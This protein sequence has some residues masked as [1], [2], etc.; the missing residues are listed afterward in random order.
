MPR[1]QEKTRVFPVP[2]ITLEPEGTNCNLHQCKIAL[3]DL[4][5]LYSGGAYRCE[6]SSEAPA[7]KLASETHNVT[8]AGKY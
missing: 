8:V 7:F 4:T 3:T 6:I 5:R 1:G 2:G